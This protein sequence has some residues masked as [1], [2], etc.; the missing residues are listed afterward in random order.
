[1]SGALPLSFSS[2]SHRALI[3]DSCSEQLAS[4]AIFLK[5][6]GYNVQ[7]VKTLKAAQEVLERKETDILFFD[8]GIPIKETISFCKYVRSQSQFQ[9]FPILAIF[10]KS[11]PVELKRKLYDIGISDYLVLPLTSSEIVSSANAACELYKLRAEKS[12]AC[13]SDIDLTLEIDREIRPL[14][15]IMSG[16]SYL[17]RKTQLTGKQHSYVR[18]IHRT[19][20]L[21][22][23]IMD[24]L[25]DYL[26]LDNGNLQIENKPFDL[27]DLLSNIGDLLIDEAESR[28]IELLF[29]VP[30]DIPRSL[31]GDPKRLERI[32]FCVLNY[33]IRHQ[34]HSIVLLRISEEKSSGYVTTLKFDI[35][36][37][38][39]DKIFSAANKLNYNKNINKKSIEDND[40]GLYLC[41]HIVE[42][43]GGKIQHV[44]RGEHH[45]GF[46]LVFSFESFHQSQPKTFAV[47][48]DIRHL[49]VLIV[50]DNPDANEILGTILESLGF[51]YQTTTSV[52]AA[53]ACIEAT[54][55]NTN[56]PNI[57]LILLDWLMP[58]GNGTELIDKMLISENLPSDIPII[59]ISAYDIS[60]FENES[61]SNRINGYLHKP[62]N[63]SILF[64]EIMTVMGQ[65]PSK[66]HVNRLDNQFSSAFSLDG[67]GKH[68]LVVEDLPLNQAIVNEVLLSHGFIVQSVQNGKEALAAIE[69]SPE[70]FDAVLM[71]IEMP[72]MNGFEAT[73]QIRS[74]TT[75]D[76]LPIIAMTAHTKEEDRLRCLDAGMN[77]HLNKPID[78][79]C[80]IIELAKQLNITHFS[81]D[82]HE[83]P[84]R[85]STFHNRR[86]VNIEEG[87]NRVVGNRELYMKLL[88]KF[89]QEIEDYYTKI[90][91]HIYE[92]NYIDAANI[93]HQLAGVAGNLSI[94]DIRLIC[95]ELQRVLE[96]DEIEKSDYL[97]EQLRTIIS[98]TKKEIE[99]IVKSESQEDIVP[100]KSNT[101]NTLIDIEADLCLR[102]LLNKIEV[103]DLSAIDYYFVVKNSHR[104]LRNNDKYIELGTLLESLDF[105]KARSSLSELIGNK[106]GSGGS[107]CLEG[108]SNETE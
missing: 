87:I 16:S 83:M 74:H 99:Q 28:D 89:S 41:K 15:D 43:I 25:I 45:V 2:F 18:N 81:G 106:S 69:E 60:K 57:D 79:D 90:Q 54:A 55:N 49:N 26:Q 29:E 85:L 80:L 61:L 66:G 73:H 63:A 86:L 71:D 10:P 23:D 21:A 68:I 42:S 3:V 47:P 76:D 96:E 40:I 22:A 93:A 51:C 14:L 1:M 98:D 82:F 4:H 50:D 72:E 31:K 77:A 103:Y 88:G 24:S 91:S 33:V 17:L 34:R 27:D 62:I 108:K 58:E 94:N 104:T 101:D 56:V 59:M 8:A 36:Q 19:A 44:F 6:A 32:L 65:A 53:T 11:P 39:T 102:E 5:A 52:R 67:S 70:L 75:C 38:C 48:M 107:S 92:D 95:K 30:L 13:K 64:D 12:L 9:H 100:D 78:P 35:E 7:S 37:K 97:I 46:S 105:D 84:S 20:I